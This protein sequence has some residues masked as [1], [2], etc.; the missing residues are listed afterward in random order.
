M[1][2]MKKICDGIYVDETEGYRSYVVEADYSKHIKS[3]KSNEDATQEIG[4]HETAPAEEILQ[5]IK[6]HDFDA[7][8]GDSELVFVE[9]EEPTKLVKELCDGNYIDTEQATAI[10][11]YEIEHIRNPAMRAKIRGS[12]S[13]KEAREIVIQYKLDEMNK[14]GSK[15]TTVG[16][17][18]KGKDR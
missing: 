15:A 16:A 8:L 12:Q 5:F 13:L 18:K 17:Q 9:T 3:I 2:I 7:E 4:L 1:A 14:S 10:M 6:K 11:M